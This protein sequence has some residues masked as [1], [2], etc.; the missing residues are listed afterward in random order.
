MNYSYLADGT[1]VS[2]LDGDG[3]GLLYLGS[4]IYRKTGSNINLE[5]AGFAGGRFVARDNG[6]VP[7]IHVTDHLDNVRAVVDITDTGE[8]VEDIMDLVLEQNDYRPFGERVDDERME[9][10]GEN[11][12]RFAGKEEQTFMNGTYSD[13]G[14]RFYS[15]DIQRWTTPDPL[16]EKYYDLSP[17]AFCNNNPINFVDPDGRFIISDNMQEWNDNKRK[18]ENKVR[19]LQQKASE[20]NHKGKSGKRL[21]KINERIKS[22]NHTLATMNN[23]EKSSQGYCLSQAVGKSVVFNMTYHLVSSI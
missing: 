9:V 8:S 5:S 13:F 20:L 14:A 22:L 17:Y 6:I 21:D 12:Y 2:A 4:L 15:S 19:L 7:M 11:R 18:I 3:D 16:A 10:D 1:K 23:I